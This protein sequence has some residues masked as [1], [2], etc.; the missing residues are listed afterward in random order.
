MEK[1]NLDVLIVDTV[2]QFMDFGQD[3]INAT[4]IVREKISALDPLCERG[5]TVILTHHTPHNRTS[6]LGSV[7][8]RNAVDSIVTLTRN[9]DDVTTV[10]IEGRSGAAQFDLVY[11][12]GRH[13]LKDE[14]DAKLR[15]PKGTAGTI[16][17]L[18][19]TLP[20]SISKNEL[21]RL[22]DDVSENTI[23]S[24]LARYKQT[25]VVKIVDGTNPQRYYR[26]AGPE[27][28][29]VGAADDVES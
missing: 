27:I 29:F 1:H 10:D 14:A 5:K 4:A 7:D 12:D 9:G 18:I 15:G 13:I 25:G 23:K 6:P 11:K 28:E 3:Q 8:W 19:P 24:T 16:I 17:D 21:V 2:V 26:D 22:L 20:N